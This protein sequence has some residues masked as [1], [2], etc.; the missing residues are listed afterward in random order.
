MSESSREDALTAKELSQQRF[1]GHAL[2][3]ARANNQ[4]TLEEVAGA[5]KIRTNQVIAM[6]EGNWTGICTDAAFAHSY[7]RNYI[8]LLG[9][10][11][12]ETLKQYGALSDQPNII[13]S[14]NSIGTT[15]SVPRK[16]WHLPRVWRWAIGVAV[17]L[18]IVWQLFDQWAV[19]SVLSEITQ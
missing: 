6:E 3:T 1:D 18:V 11:V 10:P 8:Q 2:Q 13:H 16:Q 17:A 5:L 7:L 4:W 9:L 15:L 14:V 12:E 19:S